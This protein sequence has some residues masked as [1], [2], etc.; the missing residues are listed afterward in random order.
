ME[1]PFSAHG[2][3]K[4]GTLYITLYL[5]YIIFVLYNIKLKKVKKRIRFFLKRQ[6]QEKSDKVEDIVKE[7][8]IMPIIYD[9]KQIQNEATKRDVEKIK[10]ILLEEKDT[11]IY[12]QASQDLID[13][14]IADQHPMVKPIPKS[15]KEVLVQ[16]LGLKIQK[17]MMIDWID[18]KLDD[19]NS[20]MLANGEIKL[21][22]Y[23]DKKI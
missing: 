22:R 1:W 14:I 20:F 17:R 12:Y 19:K 8:F 10:N 18:N 3:A 9:P 2:M 11:E 16:G 21:V 23:K 6:V 15:F 7:N 5:N 4:F 13:L